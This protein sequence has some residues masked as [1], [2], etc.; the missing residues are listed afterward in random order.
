MV[1]ESS[2]DSSDDFVPEESS[3]S[4]VPQ[5][6]ESDVPLRVSKATPNTPTR[7]SFSKAGPSSKTPRSFAK[8]Q[9]EMDSSDPSDTDDSF[10]ADMNA[11]QR[12]EASV[13]K[14]KGRRNAPQPRRRSEPRRRGG[15]RPK[16][17]ESDGESDN[18]DGLLEPSDDDAKPPPKGLQPHQ[19]LS[20]VKAA[21]RRM[22]KKLGR[23]LTLVRFDPVY[24]GPF[25]DNACFLA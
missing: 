2:G 19:T 22:R 17:D 13:T 24:P 1:H 14:V 15:A 10:V 16:K 25:V 9:S 18:T 12:K 3:Q 20:L 5:D 11:P 7:S 21:Q 4:D 8:A 23:K 6:E